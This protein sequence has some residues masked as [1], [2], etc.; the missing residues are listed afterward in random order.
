LKRRIEVY[1]PE[2]AASIILQSGE[3]VQINADNPKS[4]FFCFPDTPEVNKAL[5]NYFDD[6]LLPCKTFSDLSRSL[7]QQLQAMKNR[8]RW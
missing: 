3:Q 5:Q 8:V 1:S 7:R 4:L 6:V 2:K